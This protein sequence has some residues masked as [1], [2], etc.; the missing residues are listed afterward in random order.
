[1]NGKDKNKK[2]SHTIDII[3]SI[4]EKSSENY[5]LDKEKNIISKA[6]H[7]YA[8]TSRKKS[9][10][11]SKKKLYVPI[12]LDTIVYDTLLGPVDNKNRTYDKITT[13]IKKIEN[14]NEL[15]KSKLEKQISQLNK[16]IS[17]K[18]KKSQI[19]EERNESNID[20]NSNDLFNDT[21]N[22]EMKKLMLLELERDKKLNYIEV[23][24]KIKIPPEKRKIRDIIR[25]KA[26]LAQ[27]KLGNNLKEEISDMYT[28][29]K[30]INFC[31]IEMKYE[32]FKKGDI[33]YKIGDV[34]HF[35]Y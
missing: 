26:F 27:S 33:L 10:E 25:I 18:E 31:C 20:T 24:K 4:S 12:N 6:E 21:L 32:K 16:K 2:I 35:F 9:K 23:I 5:P 1:M 11:R 8:N 22:L 29:E 30:L 17:D 14:K 28:V 15:E 34:P 19:E 7:N 13:E 3:D